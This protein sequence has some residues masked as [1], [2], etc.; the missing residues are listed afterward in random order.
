MNHNLTP[1]HLGIG[2][3]KF[4]KLVQ[5]M[6]DDPEEI[7]EVYID[8]DECRMKYL[9]QITLDEAKAI[10]HLHQLSCAPVH[11]VGNWM[12]EVSRTDS[13]GICWHEVNELI[14]V[15]E[16]TETI[17]VK[18]WK[19]TCNENPAQCSSEQPQ[20]KVCLPQQ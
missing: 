5:Y 7:D 1:W 6:F 15:E 19:P 14:R 16:V 9:A 13:N 18:K 12:L 3:D 17:V 4:R 10:A 11:L 20:S 8:R 2:T